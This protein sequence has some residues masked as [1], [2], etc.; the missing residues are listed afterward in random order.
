[1]FVRRYC[2][3]KSDIESGAIALCLALCPRLCVGVDGPGGG[4]LADLTERLFPILLC[5]MLSF[6][7]L[8]VNF[9]KYNC[10][11][12]YLS[13]DV[14]GTTQTHLS[15]EHWCKEHWCVRIMVLRPV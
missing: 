2:D 1:M 10:V 14:T 15:K 7:H 5:L 4:R 3:L 13:F 6:I 12:V 8:C 9:V 11:Y